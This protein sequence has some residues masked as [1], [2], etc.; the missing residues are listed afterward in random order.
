MKKMLSEPALF[1]SDTI[2]NLLYSYRD[3][4]VYSQTCR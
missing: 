1:S 3:I 4:Q 2:L